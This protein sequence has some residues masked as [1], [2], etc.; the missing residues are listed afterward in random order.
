MISWQGRI[1]LATAPVDFRGSFDRLSGMVRDQ[2]KGDPRS[3]AFFV[4]LN[5]RADRLKVLYFDGTGDCILYKRLDRRTFSGIV[6]VDANRER[7]E[8]NVEALQRL[9]AGSD[10]GRRRSIH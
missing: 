4:F 6:A 10:R 1:F 3:G 5:R 9:L 7:V 8:I 2:L